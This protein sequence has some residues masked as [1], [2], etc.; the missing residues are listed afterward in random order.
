MAELSS[1]L[2]APFGDRLR[3]REQFANCCMVKMV[4]RVHERLVAGLVVGELVVPARRRPPARTRCRRRCR[5]NI[6]EKTR[7]WSQASAIAMRSLIALRA[8]GSSGSLPFV[9]GEAARVRRQLARA[10]RRRGRRRVGEA[11]LD[12][13]GCSRGADRGAPCR[14]CRPRPRRRVDV[15]RA[16]RRAR[17]CAARASRR[18]TARGA[19]LGGVKSAPKRRSKTLTGSYSGGFGLSG[20]LCER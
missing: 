9:V 7:V 19:R 1:T 17:S 15:G 12:A 10:P 2:P 13:C 14:P 5:E 4:R 16:R 11:V 20:P 18:R 6:I 8:L 3:A